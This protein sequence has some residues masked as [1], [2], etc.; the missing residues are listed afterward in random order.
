MAVIARPRPY[1]GDMS[2]PGPTSSAALG[3]T[4]ALVGALLFGINGSVSKVAVG[5][6]I[7]PE[8]LT[9]MRSAATAV[10]AGA[11]LLAFGRRHLRVSARELGALALLGV[12]GLAMIQWLYTLAISLLPV[13]VALLIQYTAVV[14][15][16]VFA[17]LVWRERVA[18]RLWLAIAAVLAG[19]AVVAQVWDSTLRPLGVLAAL[20][21]AVAYAFYF[22]AGERGVAKRPPLAVAFYASAFAAAFWAV[23][24]RWWTI[25]PA[26]F[27]SAVNLD[28]ALDGVEAPLWALVLWIVTLGAFAPFLLSFAALK[29]LSATAVGILASAE[30]L[31][32]FLVAWAWLGESLTSVQ[33]AGAAV[34]LAGIVIA[35]TARSTTGEGGEARAPIAVAGDTPLTPDPAGD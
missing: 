6:G 14:M 21:A 5:A 29:H 3:A 12:A 33:I 16:A 22:L 17:W 19:L 8:Q 9:L 15:V 30:V 4:Y 20:G 23:G 32:A 34:V 7:T 28:G 24:S 2:T 27:G 25:D 10:I 26:L 31:F 1:D 18:R 13:G 11:W 35:Q